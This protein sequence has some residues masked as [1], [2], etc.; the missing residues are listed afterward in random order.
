MVRLLPARGR[1]VLPHGVQQRLVEVGRDDDR[2]LGGLTNETM[3][4]QLLRR[5]GA[6]HHAGEDGRVGRVQRE[7]QLLVVEVVEGARLL[8]AV[9]VADQGAEGKP[10]IRSMSYFVN[11]IIFIDK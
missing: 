2:V 5:P 11:K 10:G 1:L 9:G 4:L 6:P 3:A 7:A 8:L